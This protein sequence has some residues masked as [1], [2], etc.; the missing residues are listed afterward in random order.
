MY[1]LFLCRSRY[2]TPKRPK[3]G[4]SE[5]GTRDKA[6]AKEGRRGLEDEARSV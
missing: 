4:P 6:K 3:P 1:V 2:R 5:A